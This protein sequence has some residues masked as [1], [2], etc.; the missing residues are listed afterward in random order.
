[1]RR[2]RVSLLTDLTF[3]SLIL[4]LLSTI[5]ITGPWQREWARTPTEEP[6]TVLVLPLALA[7]A[8]AHPR[9]LLAWAGVAAGALLCAPPFSVRPEGP[10]AWRATD[11]LARATHNPMLGRAAFWLAAVVTCALVVRTAAGVDWGMAVARAAGALVAGLAATEALLWAME[12]H[13]PGARAVRLALQVVVLLLPAVVL[14][15]LI[16]RNWSRVAAWCGASAASVVLAAVLVFDQRGLD[17]TTAV[18]AAIVMSV[19]PVWAYLDWRR[20]RIAERARGFEVQV[21]QPVQPLQALPVAA[22]QA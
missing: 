20:S 6:W 18:T 5:W 7:G 3:L 8:L 1:M 9:R 10:W 17:A 4:C 12:F 15:G 16:W 21:P 2:P 11:F 13:P 14:S 19:G 22:D